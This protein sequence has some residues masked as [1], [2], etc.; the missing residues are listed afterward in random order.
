MFNASPGQADPFFSLFIR[1]PL[2]GPFD[3]LPHI[4]SGSHT[5]I[6][7]LACTLFVLITL[8]KQLEQF[9]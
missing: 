8:L 7:V 5:G 9:E 2:P 3:A 6:L 4:V 1:Q